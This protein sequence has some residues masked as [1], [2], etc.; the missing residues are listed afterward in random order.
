MGRLLGR[1]SGRRGCAVGARPGRHADRIGPDRC[2]LAPGSRGG[3]QAASSGADRLRR[4]PDRFPARR[5]RPDRPRP[6][7]QVREARGRLD[8]VPVRHHVRRRDRACVPRDLH[9]PHV[10]ALHQAHLRREPEQP[11]HVAPPRLP[12]RG[13]RGGHELLPRRRAEDSRADP[14]AAGHG[15]AEALPGL[16]RSFPGVVAAHLLRQARASPA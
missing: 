6:L 8:L 16:G 5:A 15:P 3:G 11:V 14:G 10:V 4:V 9:E 1:G 13:R 7:P 12:R 2:R